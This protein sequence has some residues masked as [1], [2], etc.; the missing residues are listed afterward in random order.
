MRIGEQARQRAQYKKG[1]LLGLT[2]A[3]AILL[4]L[5]ALML[6]LGALL[7]RKDQNIASLGARLIDVSSQLKHE[8]TRAAV[9]RAAAEGRIT[10]EF[11]REVVLAR[12]QMAQVEMD[13]AELAEQQRTLAENQQLADALKTARDPERRLR[14]LAALGARLE[15]ETAKISPETERKDLFD[16][17]PQAIGLADAAN[18]A[19][20]EPDKARDLMNG[21]ERV[22]RENATLRGQVAR[23]RQ[24]LSRIGRGG[25]YPPCWVTESGEIQYLFDIELL[26]NGSMRVHDVTGPARLVDRRELPIPAEL[27]SGPVSRSRFISLTSPLFQHARQR[28]CRFVVIVRDRTGAAQKDLFKALLLTVEGHFYKSLRR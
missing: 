26:G 11:I 3:E 15:A 13:R 10:D 19:D 5:F 28:E 6:A 18:D 2:V 9:M 7:A 12:E 23:F 17:V 14:E 16:L 4:M 20:V 24:E 25:E 27:L 1:V 21:A 8:Q 22:T